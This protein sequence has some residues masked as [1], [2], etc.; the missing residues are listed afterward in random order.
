MDIIKAYTEY[1]S[2]RRLGQTNMYD[3]NMVQIIAVHNEFDD[4]VQLMETKKYSKILDGYSNYMK[5]I[6]E[7]K[8]SIPVA[9]EVRYC[10]QE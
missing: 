6:E 4:L 3:R 7:K 1:E 2:I 10:I 9:K 5:T 8:I